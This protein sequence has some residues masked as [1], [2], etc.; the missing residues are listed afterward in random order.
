MS[1]ECGCMLMIVFFIHSLFSCL[2]SHLLAILNWLFWVLPEPS[3][4]R[5]PRHQMAEMTASHYNLISA[6]RFTRACRS[7]TVTQIFTVLSCTHLLK[8][9]SRSQKCSLNPSTLEVIISAPH[10]NLSVILLFTAYKN[11]FNRMKICEMLQCNLN[12]PCSASFLDKKT[13]RNI[14]WT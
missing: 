10:L 14:A 7:T 4:S 1:L 2:N 12:T 8:T 11:D 3:I 5:P 6:R 13:S 9:T